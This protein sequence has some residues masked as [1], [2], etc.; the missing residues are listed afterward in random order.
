MIDFGALATAAAEAEPQQLKRDVNL[1]AVIMADGV[2]LGQVGDRLVG[3]CPFHDDE[4][5]S[6]AVWRWEDG[7]WAYGCWSCGEC[8]DLFDYIQERHACG[9]AAA[10]RIAVALR[11]GDDLPDIVPG[12]AS[13]KASQLP[14]WWAWPGGS[15]DVE[16]VTRFLR[17]RHIKVPA[18][19]V[20]HEFSVTTQRR[21]CVQIPHFDPAGKLTAMK[22]RAPGDGWQSRSV[23]GSKLDHLYG[24]WRLRGASGRDE[25]V[26]CEGES[27][28]W[29]VARW[30]DH[31]R[32]V[33]DV[34]GLP[35]GAAATPRSEWVEWMRG[36]RVVLLF[37]SD[38]AGRAAGKRWAAA[39]E[40]VASYVRIARL[41]EGLDATEAGPVTVRRAIENASGS[42]KDVVKPN[43]AEEHDEDG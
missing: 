20:M 43:N 18:D 29:S 42:T 11:D 40:G 31:G 5:P 24:I 14:A 23:A 38:D 9:F 17:D 28:T 7:C 8:G 41:P 36:R 35:S 12:D 15:G 1:A 26:V 33:P 2:E 4:S 10:M 32:Q 30:T 16:L 34:V 39:L 27:D 37:D 25:L 13:P 19:W 3:Q 22:E 6:F 21:R